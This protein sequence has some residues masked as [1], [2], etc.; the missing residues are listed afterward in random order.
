MNAYFTHYYGE[1]DIDVMC[2][3]YTYAEF[4][5]HATIFLEI[6]AK[7]LGCDRSNFKAVPNKKMA[8]IISKHFFKEC[9]WD[10]NNELGTNYTSAK[11]MQTFKIKNKFNFF[12]TNT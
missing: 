4:F 7:N 5:N 3:A 8:V 9:V 11:L 1:S 10:L 6:V 12:V 2:S